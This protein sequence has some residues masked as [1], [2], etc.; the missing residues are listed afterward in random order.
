MTAARAAGA[1]E[2]SAAGAQEHSA[3]AAP[4]PAARRGAAAAALGSG[5]LLRLELRHNAMLWLLPV[6]F[7]LFWY[8]GYREIMALP[9][10]WNLRAMTLQNRLLFD[11]IV[12]VTGAAAWMGSREGRR[13]IADLVAVTARPSW[14]RQLATWAATTAWAEAACLACVA[15][16]YLMTARQAS[17]G[18]PLWWPAVVS[19]AGVPVLTAIGFAAGAW[20]P[21]RFVTPLVTAVVFF[22]LAFG[23]QAT[24]GDHS[25]WQ[26]SPLTAGAFDI[27]AAPGVASF[28]PYLPD[29]SIAQVMFTAGLVIAVLGALG[30]PV[31]R[32]RWLAA[33]ITA[34]GLA[35]AGTAVALAGTGRLDPHGMIV[36]PALHDAAGDQPVRYT[37]ACSRTP[38]PVC[39]HPAYTGFL[40]AVTAAIGSEL[41]EFAGL[42]GAPARIS[43]VTAVYRQEPGNGISVSGGGTSAAAFVLPDEVPGRLGTTGAEFAAQLDEGLGLQLASD[44]TLGG[45]GRQSSSAPSQAQLAVIAGSVRFPSSVESRDLAP[46]YGRLLPQPGS[47]ADRAARRFAALSPAA[48]HAWLA[49]HLAALR[50]GRISLAQL[51]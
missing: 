44:M 19:A 1:Q 49:G 17:W 29:L 31:A 20:F 34:A 33:V 13:G 32:M 41:T 42:P 37:P 21:G 38:I 5:R 40:P 16:V 46:L 50:S 22:G 6:A 8:N 36:I 10:M 11:L 15:V 35:A 2:H 4:R 23:T 18:G 30:I 12:P 48:R 51:P 14:S 27:G 3:P 43:Q 25:Y 24:S 47:P 45:D 26:V 39:V 7:A 9:P 28:Y